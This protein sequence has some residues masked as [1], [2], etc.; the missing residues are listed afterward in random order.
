MIQFWPTPANIK[1]APNACSHHQAPGRKRDRRD[2]PHAGAIIVFSALF[3]PVGLYHRI[4]ADTGEKIDRWQEGLIVLFGLRI[5]AAA[6]FAFWLAWLINPA[7]LAWSHVPIPPAAR[8]LGV[9]LAM[10]GGLSWTWALHHLGK[11]LTDTVITRRQHYLVTT[12][13]YRFVRHPFYSSVV[14]VLLGNSL[15]TANGL[16]IVLCAVLWFG[17]L[18]PRTRIEEQNLMNRFGDEYRNYMGRVGRFI[19]RLGQANSE[20]ARPDA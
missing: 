7:W 14:M 18:L 6:T 9:A 19:P 2:V 16:I 4:R 10:I 12:G 15:A 11:N 17:F 20:A 5:T 1:R 8:W 13:P 3:L